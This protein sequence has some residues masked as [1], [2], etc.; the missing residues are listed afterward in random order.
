MG[1]R[2]I[3]PMSDSSANSGQSQSAFGKFDFFSLLGLALLLILFYPDLFLARSASLVADHWEQHY[4]WAYCLADA[5][6][7]FRLPFW[8]N[9][10]H[11]G[12]PI[13]AE[14][15]IGSFYLPNL[16]LQL[17]LPFRWAYAYANVFHFLLSGIGMYLYGRTV[18]MKPG[19][20]LVAACVYLFGTAYGGAYYN[21]TSL[22]V[23][24]W[25]PL[26][27]F[28]F[29]RLCRR[30]N[31]FSALLLAL[32]LAM[33]I[34]AGYLQVAVFAIFMFMIYVFLRVFV[35]SAG[36][37]KTFL[38]KAKIL[39]LVSA[40]L[41]FGM[42]MA[43][44]QLGLTYE[45]SLRSNRVGVTEAYAYVGSMSPFAVATVVLGNLQYLFRGNSF[46]LGVF[47][48]FLILFAV[49]SPSARKN[50]FLRVWS[51]MIVISLL[52]AVGQWSPVFVA[53]IK[54]THFYSF[55]TPMKFLY[56][57]CFGLSVLAGLGFERA[58]QAAAGREKSPEC[59]KAAGA[60]QWI[61]AAFCAAGAVLYVLLS[62]GRPWV[63][64][65][66]TWF[67]ER[68]IY[69]QA[70]HPHS[71]E[72]YQGKLACYLDGVAG[73]FDL[74]QFWNL[75]IYALVLI[76]VLMAVALRHR[77]QMTRVW[78]CAGLVF[79]LVDLYAFT[80][81]D[82]RR[83]FDSYA[84][85][86]AGLSG[87]AVTYL[88]KEQAL[89]RVGRIYGF[90]KPDEKLPLIPSVNF[91]SGVADIG[92]YSPLV[93]KRYFETV[94]QLG[95]V[96]DSNGAFAPEPA[97]VLE[98]LPLLDSLNVTHVLSS[99]P[100]QHAT[101]QLIVKDFESG[102]F[103]YQ[104]NGNYSRAHFVTK[105][106]IFKD[107]EALK[108]K[109]ME[110]GFDPRGMMLIEQ[111]EWGRAGAQQSGGGREAV[112]LIRPKMQ[113]DEMRIWEVETDQPGF[114]VDPTMMYPGWSARVN[115]KEQPVLYGY[116]MFQT[117]WLSKPGKYEI[118]FKYS[119]FGSL[120]GGAK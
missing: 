114:F 58:W 79:L 26:S 66:G 64:K 47:S 8:T 107:W 80:W 15:Q 53:L 36:E 61:I 40:A 19:P 82:I 116:G 63:M 48:V 108:A 5:L 51:A 34:L 96:N 25:F 102:T 23:L 20:A 54:L 52:L 115:G 28:F 6:R 2:L 99:R 92:A 4:P 71:L 12:F 30:I 118:R 83:D 120:C 65:M 37:P 109:L 94:G 91:L 112:A 31:F 106:E 60:Y 81:R 74:G 101:L 49:Y 75:W 42:V 50:S 43:L 13:T 98:R 97:F 68:F 10:I 24:S 7:E 105:A 55:R 56:F 90:R 29:E 77:N 103:L 45:L 59:L 41:F 38:W 95:N 72:V 22:K 110:P 17:L 87:P 62:V 32:S 88:Q 39:F 86:D 33:A 46:Y 69:Q 89:G 35:I 70:G 113:K 44:P 76:G 104:N 111:S 85:A 73:I 18:R 9:L 11:C 67:T 16:V 21:I 119:P 100:L 84:H 3:Y 27:L 117:I 93:M 14:S 78:L 57:A 1:K